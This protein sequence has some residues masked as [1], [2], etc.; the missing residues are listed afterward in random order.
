MGSLVVT[1]WLCCVRLVSEACKLGSS[2]SLRRRQSVSI[3]HDSKLSVRWSDRAFPLLSRLTV[4]LIQ[5]RRTYEPALTDVAAKAQWRSDLSVKLI[6]ALL[7]HSATSPLSSAHA[8]DR[9]TVQGNTLTFNTDALSGADNI[10]PRIIFDDVNL[11]GEL[12]M[13]HPEVDTVI[14]SG[15]GGS[16]VAAYDIA[17]KIAAFN[18]NTIARNNCSSACTYIFLG[19]AKRKLEG[20]ARLGF[21]RTSRGTSYLRDFYTQYKDDLGWIDEFAFAQD[22]FEEGQIAAREFIDF[23]TRRGVD[24]GFALRVISYGPSDMWYPS[25][26]DLTDANILR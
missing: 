15:G 20:G 26:Q 2:Q 16:T 13:N 24:L 14:V 21:H 19:G 22:V 6:V 8:Q 9:M 23:A 18:L 11:F 7:V 10:T 12:L 5:L 25:D 3:Q 17:N 1:S 4:V